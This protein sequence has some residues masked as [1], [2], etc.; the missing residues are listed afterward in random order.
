MLD[1]LWIINP[2]PWSTTQTSIFLLPVK[3]VLASQKY[4]LWLWWTVPCKTRKVKSTDES[5]CNV[6]VSRVQEYRDIIRSSWGRPTMP[7]V[8]TRSGKEEEITLHDDIDTFGKLSHLKSS[9]Q[10]LY[11]LNIN[12]HSNEYILVIHLIYSYRFFHQDKMTFFLKIFK[13]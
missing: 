3:P 1:L 9:V 5:C 12:K 10:K 6:W 11:N 13:H 4:I 2:T 8:V 7:G